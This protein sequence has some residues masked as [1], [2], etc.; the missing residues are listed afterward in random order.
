MQEN[1]IVRDANGAD[2]PQAGTAPN[3]NLRLGP[4]EGTAPAAADPLA[5]ADV[6]EP[7]MGPRAGAPPETLSIPAPE[8]L[9]SN[10]V[11]DRSNS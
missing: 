4:M 2:L 5:T 11:T 10:S 6:Q 1:I 9:S 3:V 7:S 8:G